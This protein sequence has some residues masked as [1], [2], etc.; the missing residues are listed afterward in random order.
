MLLVALLLFFHLNITYTTGAHVEKHRRI[1]G[2]SLSRN[3]EP[4]TPGGSSGLE[5]FH[6]GNDTFWVYG[7]FWDYRQREGNHL[8]YMHPTYEN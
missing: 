7:A 2:E 1:F 4:L 3:T 8:T 5:W 6:M